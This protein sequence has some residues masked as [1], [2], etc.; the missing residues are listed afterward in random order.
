M[1][2]KPTDD[3]LIVA[4]DT[5]DAI[6][7]MSIVNELGKLVGFYKIGLGLLYD[8]GMEL[9]KR[10]KFNYKKRVFLDL[11]LFDISATVSASIKSVINIEPD[12]LTVHGDPHIVRA[13]VKARQSSPTKI[14]A[15]TVLT[16]LDRTD[17]DESM[18]VGG[19]VATVAIERAQRA[20]IAGADGVISSPLEAR[21]IR[22]LPAAKDRL[23]VTPGT[24]PLGSARSDQKRVA[25]PS[26]AINNGAD[27][28]VIGRPITQSKYPRQ[29]VRKI[30]EELP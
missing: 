6:S 4:L 14:L 22:K 16:S 19:N 28:F 8:G 2:S 18:V 20:L 12:F 25:T 23:I 3:R 5:A 1:T 27:H 15:I 17:L 11:K 24:R 29:I 21:L 26:E 30:L 10:L 7:A 13:A 9:A